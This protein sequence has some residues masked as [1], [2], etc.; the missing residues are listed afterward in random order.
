VN[1][2]FLTTVRKVL[3]AN[4]L[5]LPLVLLGT[6]GSPSCG[7]AV[8]QVA[9]NAGSDWLACAEADAGGVIGQAVAAIEAL[10]ALNT[11]TLEADALALIG[12]LGFDAVDCAVKIVEELIAAATS[13]GSGSGNVAYATI[14]GFDRVKLTAGVVR[15]R[16]VVERER[17]KY[18]AARK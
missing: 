14:A 9:A 7:G 2:S 10:G 18:A 17:P 5:V 1:R 16:A 13:T 4:L 6:Y 8:G 12:T 3:I 15:I 11:A